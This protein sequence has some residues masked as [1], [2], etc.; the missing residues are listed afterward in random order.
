MGAEQDPVLGDLDGVTDDSDADGLP[1]VATL[2]NHSQTTRKSH[3]N[4]WTPLPA[5]GTL[6]ETLVNALRT[7]AGAVR[8]TNSY[9]GLATDV[10]RLPWRGSDCWPGQHGG[11][12]RSEIR[13]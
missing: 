2:A 10:L 4:R 5:G 12:N 3:L 8:E 9:I 7:G 6:V 13:R 1:P 11:N